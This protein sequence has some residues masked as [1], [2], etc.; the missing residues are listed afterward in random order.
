MIYYKYI[1]YI[2]IYIYLFIY[3]PYL[4]ASQVAPVVKNTPANASRP[5]RCR[6]DP[7]VGKIPWRRAWQLFLSGKSHDQRRLA[8]MVHRVAKSQTGLKWLTTQHTHSTLVAQGRPPGL[9]PGSG[10]TPRGG[11]GNS[12]QYSCLGNSMDRG[13]CWA[14]VHGVSKSLTQLNNWTHIPLIFTYK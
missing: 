7:W 3:M 9:I 14:T 5:K 4:G 6:F 1:F 12:L 11:H 10:R 13:A 2:Y 8:A